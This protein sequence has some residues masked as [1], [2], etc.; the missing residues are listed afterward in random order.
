MGL[1][2]R[3]S[4]VIHF[5]GW[6]SAKRDVPEIRQLLQRFGTEVGRNMFGQNFWVNQ[7]IEKATRYE[8]VV[9]SDCRYTNEA[10][11]IKNVGGAVWRISRP[12]VTAIN[13]HASEQDLNNYAFDLHIENNST[14]ENLHMLIEKQ[15]GL[16]WPSQV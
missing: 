3:L 13:S 7:A 10:D 16:L 15:L 4:G 6:D 5:R 1:H 12:E 14:L 9:F 2:M 8:R 11:A